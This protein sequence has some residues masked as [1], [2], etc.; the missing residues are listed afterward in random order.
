MANAFLKPDPLCGSVGVERRRI[1]YN[2]TTA[3]IWSVLG[4]SM[5]FSDILPFPPLDGNIN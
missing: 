1:N 5:H 3:K 2:R 4:E